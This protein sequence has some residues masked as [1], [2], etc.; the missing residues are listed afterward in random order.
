MRAHVLS[1]SHLPSA[2][3]HYGS[4]GRFKAKPITRAGMAWNAMLSSVLII[5]LVI[6]CFM[7]GVSPSAQVRRTAEVRSARL[8]GWPDQHIV[9]LFS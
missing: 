2:C 6:I 4:F 5:L 8:I 9:L 1:S 3:T 7:K